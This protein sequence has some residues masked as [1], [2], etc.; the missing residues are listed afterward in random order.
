MIKTTMKSFYM[1]SHTMS[2]ELETSSNKDFFA[3]EDLCSVAG[4]S[5]TDELL[6]R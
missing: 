3:M 6:Q 1:Y 4:L 5:I 2:T